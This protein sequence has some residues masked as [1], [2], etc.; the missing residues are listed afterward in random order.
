[1]FVC[2]RHT[3]WPVLSTFLALSLSGCDKPQKQVVVPVVEVGVVTLTA[4]DVVLTTE[5]PGRTAPYLV[6]E[7]RPQ[8]GGIL[9]P[10]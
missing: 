2:S 1:M 10:L 7:I 6:A 9:P 5:L 8:V 3:V 4:K